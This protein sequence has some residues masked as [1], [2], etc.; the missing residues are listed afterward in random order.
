MDRDL[1]TRKAEQTENTKETSSIP[2]VRKYIGSFSPL[3]QELA[4]T[5]QNLLR[6]LNENNPVRIEILE[7]LQNFTDTFKDLV[8]QAEYEEY[9]LAVEGSRGEARM[10]TSFI[11]FRTIMQIMT[12][13]DGFPEDVREVF[14][15]RFKYY[16]YYSNIPEEHLK[17]VGP[18]YLNTLHD[19][20]YLEY[21]FIDLWGRAT[22]LDHAQRG[23]VPG[24]KNFWYEDLTAEVFMRGF[25]ELNQRLGAKIVP[26]YIMAP[27]GEIVKIKAYD[28]EERKSRWGFFALTFSKFPTIVCSSCVGTDLEIFG[29]DPGKPELRRRFIETALSSTGEHFYIT[30]LTIKDF[31]ENMI[32]KVH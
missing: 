22:K 5:T 15:R 28:A 1:E 18:G 8:S 3:Q 4:E 32:P 25:A 2:K 14:E 30:D 20:K 23:Y 10:T 11:Q 12:S 13:V 7:A 29:Y 9:L 31:R 27:K 21:P 17:H 16:K 19:Y 6:A 26:D 24:P